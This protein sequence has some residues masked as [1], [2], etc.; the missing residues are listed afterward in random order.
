LRNELWPAPEGEHRGEIAAFLAHA[1]IEPEAVLVVESHDHDLVGFVELSGRNDLA[2]L[3]GKAVGYVEGMYVIPQYRNT[4]IARRL[5]Q[6]SR[7]WA[8]DRSCEFFGS[9]R[10]ERI[11]MDPSF[12][13]KSEN[14]KFSRW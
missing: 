4:G 7:D 12:R 6:A 10:A 11:I 9:D 14:A 5:L 2:G 13:E 3:E 8:R 1:L